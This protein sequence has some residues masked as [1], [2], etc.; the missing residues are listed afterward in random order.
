MRVDLLHFSR[1]AWSLRTIPSHRSHLDF[2]WPRSAFVDRSRLRWSL[3]WKSSY[4]YVVRAWARACM[5]TSRH[6]CDLIR[7][8]YYY[9]NN[10]VLHAWC[11]CMH[12]IDFGMSKLM[13]FDL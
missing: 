6:A 1:V 7:V 3:R 13:I 12:V 4:Q 8:I 9:T 5:Y 2:F 11:M 10:L